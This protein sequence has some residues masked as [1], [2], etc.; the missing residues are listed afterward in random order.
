MIS[1][2]DL[3]ADYERFAM[4]AW[5]PIVSAARDGTVIEIKNDYGIA[6][7]YGLHK[8]VSGRGWV[9]ATDESSECG[10]GPWLTWRPYEGDPA[11]YTDPT[12]GAQES[13]EYWQAASGKNGGWVGDLFSKLYGR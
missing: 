6:P 1:Q 2:S 5:Q 7:W 13:K 10:D 12:N 4:S 3:F 8:W 9:S 11:Q